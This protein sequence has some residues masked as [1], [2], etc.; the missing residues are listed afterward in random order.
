MFGFDTPGDYPA[1]M[2]DPG[3]LVS[4]VAREYD[5]H[6]RMGQA[7]MNA[8][9]Q[10]AGYGWR[11]EGDYDL[12][13]STFRIRLSRKSLLRPENGLVKTWQVSVPAEEV[14]SHWRA[15]PPGNSTPTLS[16]LAKRIMSILAEQPDFPKREKVEPGKWYE[17]GKGARSFLEAGKGI[18]S[19]KRAA[20]G[21]EVTMDQLLRAGVIKA[22]VERPEEPAVDQA[23]ELE[24]IAS[25]AE[26]LKKRDH[27]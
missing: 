3:D 14:W 27:A 9:V 20:E 16:A 17:A 6:D 25:I 1:S 5:Q 8:V 23:E 13:S 18:E 7:L 10:E 12:E 4:K 11:A 22:P 2:S 21:T 15:A 19:F 24:A 26:T